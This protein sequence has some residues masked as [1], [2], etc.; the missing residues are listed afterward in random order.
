MNSP[1]TSYAQ[2]LVELMQERDLL[3]ITTVTAKTLTGFFQDREVVLFIKHTLIPPQEKKVIL[4][5]MVPPGTPREFV[6]FLN[7]IIDRGWGRILPEILET[8][9]RLS[10]V[11]QGYEIVT[12]ISAQPLTEEEKRSI[13]G[14][15]VAA[16]QVDIYPEF[17]VNPNLL[18]GIIIQRGDELYDGSLQG[19]LYEI[20]KALINRNQLSVNS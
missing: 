15:L 7:L 12:L 13:L 19:Q 2:A 1:V 11:K 16:W 5:K 10:I 4:Q 8:V 6:N 18:G 14:E 20:K 9:V 3:D 17:R